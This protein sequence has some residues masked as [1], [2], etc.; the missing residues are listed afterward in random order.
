MVKPSKPTD[1]DTQQAA[2]RQASDMAQAVKDSAQQIW[3]AG[4]GAFAK[5]QEEGSRVFDNLVKEGSTLQKKSQG[6]AEE[7]L[8]TVAGKVSAMAEDVSSK[9]GAQWGKLESIFE[10]RVARALSKMGVPSS[11][12]VAALNK[13]I[14]ELSAKL[15]A[16]ATPAKKTAAR[17]PPAKPA[18]KAAAKRAP[19]KKSL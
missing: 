1:D 17:R 13:R 4:M 12:D 6:L 10:Q 7:S 14:D 19:R 8:S 5:A 2:G 16:R 18:V 11:E 3:L 9:A 15:R